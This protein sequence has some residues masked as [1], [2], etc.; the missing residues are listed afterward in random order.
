MLAK[1][2][3]LK[4]GLALILACYAGTGSASTASGGAIS[5]ISVEQGKAFFYVSGSRTSTPACHTVPGRWVFNAATADGQAMLS[6]LM[7]FYSLGKQIQVGGTG[8][9]TDWAD[10]ETVRYIWLMN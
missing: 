10:T 7:T 1:H 9:C 6:A 4:S 2:F 5:G 3:A 8:A